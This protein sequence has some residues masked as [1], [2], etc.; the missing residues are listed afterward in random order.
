[1]LRLYTFTA[2][3]EITSAFLNEF[4]DLSRAVDAPIMGGNNDLGLTVT[5][6]QGVI[7]QTPAI[8]PFGYDLPRLLDDSAV[9]L[10]DWRDRFLLDATCVFYPDAN[11]RVGGTT[12]TNL[13]AAASPYTTRVQGKYMGT[14]AYSSTGATTPVS[15]GVP[16]VNGVGAVRSYA[17]AL[18]HHFGTSGGPFIYA[19]PTTGSLYLYHRNPSTA[20]IHLAL[21]LV[22]SAQTGKRP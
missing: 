5:G 10:V 3:E 15:A 2:L 12:D 6:E 22:F 17:I 8:S 1:M 4:Q 18:S 21:H 19:S 11:T 20:D 7:I 16:P 13:N 9:S 14:G